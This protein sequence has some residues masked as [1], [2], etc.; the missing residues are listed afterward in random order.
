MVDWFSFLEWSLFIF[1]SVILLLLVLHTMLRI[2]KKLYHTP[3]PA[4]ATR[5]I[6]N[7][8][9]RKF[10]QKPEVIVERMQIKSGMTVIEIGP[11]KGSYTKAV[12]KKVLPN[13]KVFAIDI[14]ES[15]VEYLQRRFKR[16]KISNVVPMLDDAHN[17]SFED[18]SVDRIFAIA[19]LP[20]IPDPVGVLRE[21]KR[22]LKPDGLVC[23]FEVF[24]DPDYPWRR[25]EVRW[26]EEAGLE[27]RQQFGTW[28]MYQ[29]NFG[30]K[31]EG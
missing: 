23:L 27:L 26:A 15:V 31:M 21:C 30:K 7:P 16:E 12:A 22:I 25:T 5:L 29:L 10:F 18:E 13:G 2:I 11:G 9:R 17:F 20:E 4:F 19:C 6:D 24:I 1:F 3:A 28:F 14:Q 8:I